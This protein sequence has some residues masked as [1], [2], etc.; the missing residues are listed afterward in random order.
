LSKKV[1][2]VIRCLNENSNLKVLIPKL[3]NQTYKNYEIVFVDSGSTDGTLDT[4]TKYLKI[5][6]E[7]YLYHIKKNEFTFGKSLNLGFS[8]TSGNLIV[9]LSAHCFPKNI[10]WLKSIVDSF[11]D[12]N[13]GIVYGSQSPHPETRHS[14][15]SVQKSWFSG[16]S[17][18]RKDIFLNNGNAAYRKKVWLEN[19]FDEKLTGLED[20]DLGKK[21]AANNWKIFYC[22]EANVEHL[23][24]ENYKTILNRYRREAEAMKN[25]NKDIKSDE[26][27][28][29][30]TFFHCIKGFFRGVI[31][32]LKTSKD[33]PQPSRD[34]ISILRYRFCQYL[35]TYKGYKNNMSRNKIT[36]LYFYPPKI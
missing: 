31:Y 27:I 34:I 13:V 3:L 8:K 1:S 15:A 35:G 19:K 18:I 26:H 9:S 10:Y 33:S 30:N 23:H 6:E 5:N 29:K 28:I 11:N 7:F 25:I 16:N 20:I 32:D 36:D 14:E 17:R 12:Q 22:A 2:I 24:N 21:A 4:I